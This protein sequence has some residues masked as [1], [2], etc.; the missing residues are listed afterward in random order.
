[1]EID[2]LERMQKRFTRAVFWR[3]TKTN[4]PTADT[5]PTYAKLSLEL[6]RQRFDLVAAYRHLNKSLRSKKTSFFSF[7]PEPQD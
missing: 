4:P 1:Q 3:M 7:D 5:I 6:R 2:E